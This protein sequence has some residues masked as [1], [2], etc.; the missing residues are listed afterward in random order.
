[1]V[2]PSLVVV[3][4]E[5]SRHQAFVRHHLK[6]L[7]FGSHDVRWEALPLGRGCGEQWV[8]TRYA[9]VV[10]ELRRRDS[11]AKTALVVVIDEDTGRGA[12]RV[13]QLAIALTESQQARRSSEERIVH[14]IPKRNI[15]TWV[16]C[17]VGRGVNEEDDYSQERE[18]DAQ[19]KPAADTYYALTRREASIPSHVVPSLRNGVEEAR[20]LED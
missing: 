18:V 20:R 19:I 14:L 5:D 6:R 7:G 10:K 2:K 4:A 9:G 15:E 8:R 11:K 12:G 13:S 17:L 3:L 1:M 16:L